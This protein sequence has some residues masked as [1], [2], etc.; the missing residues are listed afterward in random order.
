MRVEDGIVHVHHVN[1]EVSRDWL[2]QCRVGGDGKG[3]EPHSVLGESVEKM[4]LG[5]Q[6]E[7]V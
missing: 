6:G 2:E 7:E 3:G 4:M 1:I 5:C